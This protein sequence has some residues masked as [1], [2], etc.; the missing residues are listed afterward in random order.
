M[1]KLNL[2]SINIRCKIR[3]RKRDAKMIDNVPEMDPERE[4]KSINMG[5]APV[6]LGYFVVL[7]MFSVSTISFFSSRPKAE[8]V[9]KKVLKLIK[10]VRKYIQN[11]VPEHPFES[12]GGQGGGLRWGT[13]HKR[14]EFSF[15]T[16]PASSLGTL[17]AI[18][19]AI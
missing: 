14:G 8:E 19:D 12:P 15:W 11:E 5:L 4:P 9:G 6:V 10:N 7:S 18:L 3:A 13:G 1:S 17:L 2:K 16:L